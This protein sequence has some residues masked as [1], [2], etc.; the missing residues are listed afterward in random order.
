MK[1]PRLWQ[2]RDIDALFQAINRLSGVGM[3]MAPGVKS[4]G[5][6]LIENG[7]PGQF[8]GQG[9]LRFP[10]SGAVFELTVPME[11]LRPLTAAP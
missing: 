5:T 4:F 11:R 7:I 10:A 9:N 2:P 3:V 8:G 6:R 1:S